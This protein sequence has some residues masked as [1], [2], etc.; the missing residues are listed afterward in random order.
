MRCQ[1][2][3]MLTFWHAVPG[4][5]NSPVSVELQT[6]TLNR[7][8]QLMRMLNPLI[9]RSP[10]LASPSTDITCTH[11]TVCLDAITGLLRANLQL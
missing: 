10:R 8:R 2:P 5:L 3:L 7:I 11:A 1:I 9:S 6:H 4:L